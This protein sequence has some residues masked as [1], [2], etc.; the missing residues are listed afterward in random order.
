MKVVAFPKRGHYY[1]EKFYEPVIAAGTQVEEG[2]FSGRW[3]LRNLNRGD[4]VH[5]HWP[6]FS[7]AGAASRIDL[8]KGFARF[9]LLLV[10]IRLKRS[11]LFWTAHN[12]MPH[13][14]VGVP[15]LDLLG[16][17]IL[18]SLTERI[19]THGEN[20]ARIL[21]DRFP[22]TRHKIVLIQHGHFIGCY[23]SGVSPEEARRALGIEQ[24]VFVYLFIGACKEYKNVD[25][26]ISAFKQLP[27]N[28][29]L[30]IAGKYQSPSYQKVIEDLARDIPQIRLEPRYIP[31][32]ELQNYLKAA[33]AVVIPYREIL[34]SGTAM[35]AFSFGKPVVSVRLGSLEDVVT[36]ETGILYDPDQPSGL[37]NAMIEA[38][39]RTFD[40]D[41]ILDHARRFDWET[42]ARAFLAV[43]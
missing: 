23:P 37:I 30:L 35:L 4:V 1:N 25:G 21:A 33:C 6:S 22:S 38:R 7:Y 19:F 16:R 42:S 10:L 13:D 31:D 28:S 3:L 15:Y 39:Q 41:T 32:E 27:G 9:A 11:R 8:C 40:M 14:R 2:V 36:S 20:A 18:I 5:V 29:M 34:T 24:S 26:L 43:L 17:L 12:L